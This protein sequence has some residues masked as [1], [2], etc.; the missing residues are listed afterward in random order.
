MLKR[1]IPGA[2]VSGPPMSPPSSAAGPPQPPALPPVR[3]PQEVVVKEVR[4]ANGDQVAVVAPP[5][6]QVPE[7]FEWD[8]Q[9]MRVADLLSQGIP[10][11]RIVNLPGM[12]SSRTTVYNWLKHPDFSNYVNRLVLEQGLVNQ[13]ERMAAMKNMLNMLYEKFLDEFNNVN[14]TDKNAASLLEKFFAGLRQLTEDMK[15]YVQ[16]VQVQAEHNVKQENVN[17][18]IATMLRSSPEEKRAKIEKEFRDRADTILR[19]MVAPTGG[20]S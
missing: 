11:S 8:A 17:I 14:I 12:P 9:K 18:D 2:A 5:S 6:Y 20:E 1:R 7:I 15:G 13:A 3:A 4:L 10:M 16:Q 19:Q